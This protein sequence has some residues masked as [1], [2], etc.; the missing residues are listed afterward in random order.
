MNLESEDDRYNGFQQ[1]CSLINNTSIDFRNNNYFKSIVENVNY[2]YGREYYNLI[3]KNY[4]SYID[5]ISWDKIENYLISVLNG[6]IEYT[7][8]NQKI[9]YTNYFKIYF[10]YI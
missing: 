4:S 9:D 2:T 3:C 6:N 10:I 1:Y 7:F 8:N 5:K